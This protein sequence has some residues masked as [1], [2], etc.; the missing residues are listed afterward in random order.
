MSGNSPQ[1]L[2]SAGRFGIIPRTMTKLLSPVLI[3]AVLAVAGCQTSGT[4][5]AASGGTPRPREDAPR[6]IISRIAVTPTPTDAT[7]EIA[8]AERSAARGKPAPSFT[9]P[10][11]KD[12]QVSLQSLRGQWV[13]LYFYPADDTPGCGCQA[14]EFTTLLA[15]FRGHDATVMGVSP[16]IPAAHRRFIRKYRLAIPLLSDPRKTVMREY[17]A[18]ADI[19]KGPAA[20]GRVIRSTYLID[21]QGTIAFHWPEVIP[22]GHAQRV[23]DKLVELKKSAPAQA[24][25]ETITST[26]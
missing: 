6:P 14:T 26:D 21:P 8:A 7:I 10:N 1:P 3:A 12:Q 5:G 13:V 25:P 22:Q 9:L 19:E 24:K 11:Q 17:G 15:S 4:G 16:D 18:W 2:D 23:M 20:P